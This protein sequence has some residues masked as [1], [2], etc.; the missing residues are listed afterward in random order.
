MSDEEKSGGASISMRD[1][2]LT[3]LI[4]W[5]WASL[6]AVG[7]LIGV[8]VYNKLADLNDTII[9]AVVQIENQS[10]EI[11]DIKAQQAEMRK[12]ME[13]MRNQMYSLEGKTLRGIS[14]IGHAK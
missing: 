11:K 5:V 9:R 8:G 1:G 3:S 6:G 12:D 10:N 7:L 4:S 2:R 14:E 13:S